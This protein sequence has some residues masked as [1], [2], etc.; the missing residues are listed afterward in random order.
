MKEISGD[1]VI[2]GGGI[3]AV[4][5]AQELSAQV[6]E[7]SSIIVV[8]ASAIVK[9]AANW[10]QVRLWMAPILL[11]DGKAHIQLDPSQI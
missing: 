1:Y 6:P 4:S 11:L 5:C 8:S 2:V 9:A 10:R 7:S 3:A